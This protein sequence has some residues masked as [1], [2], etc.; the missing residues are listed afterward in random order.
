[1]TRIL[2]EVCVDSVESAI[3]AVNGG[4][5]RLELCGNLGLGGG[6]T[7]SIGSYRAVRKA[8][9]DV[10]IMVMIRPRT[11]DFLYSMHEQ[12]VMLDD[13]A[14]FKAEGAMGVVFGAL[15]KEGDVDIGTTIR[16]LAAARP[17]EVCFHRA[18]DM[19]L[20]P[21]EAFRALKAIPGI[22]RVLTSGHSERAPSERS[23]EIL[24]TFFE[25]NSTNAHSSFKPSI[26]PG[27]GI[28]PKTIGTV[29][30]ALLP[31][32]LREV[33]LSAGAWLASEMIHKPEGMGMGVG[34][35]GEWGIWRTK[36]HVV[37]AVRQAVDD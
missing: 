34:G 8:A 31:L 9:K 37:R 32:G 33:H 10:P 25:M 11:G 16:L 27:S 7:P 12:Q 3:A 20:D 19:T 36:E 21:V 18:I 6:T 1:M 30:D 13:I 35:E 14:Q 2:V 4:A 24:K 22:T 28:N 15:S 17:M 29:M 26:L 23:L 5:D